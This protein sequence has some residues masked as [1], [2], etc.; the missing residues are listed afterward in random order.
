MATEQLV[1]YD[2]STPDIDPL[3]VLF[4]GN[5]LRCHVERRA[6]TEVHLTIGIKKAGKA[7][8]GQFDDQFVAAEHCEHVF[9]LE[10]SMRQI[11]LVHVV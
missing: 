6:E 7:E 4:K 11:L 1:G 5:Q 10:I 9:R 3:I 8:V 2:A